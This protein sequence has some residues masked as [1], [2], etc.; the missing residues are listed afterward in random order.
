M[1]YCIL[2]IQLLGNLYEILFYWKYSNH[3][4]LLLFLFYI[5]QFP[6]S[7]ASHAHTHT[8]T[9]TFLHSY[10]RWFHSQQ[11]I[12][13][14]KQ[15]KSCNLLNNNKWRT[16]VQWNQK[17]KATSNNKEKANRIIV[18]GRINKPVIREMKVTFGEWKSIGSWWQCEFMFIVVIICIMCWLLCVWYM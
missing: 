16:L 4:S 14:T 12:Q 5:F 15:K 18:N 9:H 11:N 3:S 13:Q 8:H 1:A 17:T 10:D 7:R 2:F 6:I